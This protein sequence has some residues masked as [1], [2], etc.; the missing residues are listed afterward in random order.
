MRLRHN[1]RGA[2]WRC[3]GTSEGPW[4]ACGEEVMLPEARLEEFRIGSQ[5]WAM[6][7]S[8]A[9]LV[10]GYTRVWSVQVRPPLP[11]ARDVLSR[12]ELFPDTPQ[13]DGSTWY[14]PGHLDTCGLAG[15]AQQP[16]LVRTLLPRSARRS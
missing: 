1:P 5:L 8:H 16:P 10:V 9:R 4:V 14:S 15:H 2:S 3:C 7:L 13:H 12:R 6:T 11:E